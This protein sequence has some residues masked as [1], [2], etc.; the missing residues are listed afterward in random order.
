MSTFRHLLF[1]FYLFF[2]RNVKR[3][4]NHTKI[5]IFVFRVGGRGRMY[6]KEK[7][8]VWKSPL[9][10]GVHEQ[11]TF[12]SQRLRSY[13]TELLFTLRIKKNPQNSWSCGMQKTCKYETQI[14]K[15]PYNM[16]GGMRAREGGCW[17]KQKNKTL[18]CDL[19]LSQQSWRCIFWTTDKQTGL[20]P[21]LSSRAWLCRPAGGRW[22]FRL[23]FS[24]M[25]CW[26]TLKT[27][28]DKKKQSKASAPGGTNSEADFWKCLWR[29]Y[30]QMLP[31]DVVSLSHAMSP[32]D[33]QLRL[34]TL[35][36]AVSKK[37]VHL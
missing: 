17:L 13:F 4:E 33:P 22:A 20:G 36:V 3:S 7:A 21:R 12:T 27:P 34:Y 26:V 2:K 1:F 8:T 18:C 31:L 28:K 5:G 24:I 9:G 30:S 14:W 29:L 23:P 16:W 11:I 6:C 19:S 32:H 25:P 35:S 37:R 10:M 15:Q